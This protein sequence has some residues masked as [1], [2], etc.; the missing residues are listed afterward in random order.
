MAQR[1]THE[2]SSL[3]ELCQEAVERF[4]DDWQSIQAYMTEHLSQIAAGERKMLSKE[5]E[6]TLR[7]HAPERQKSMH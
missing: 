7:F 3:A 5:I 2:P 4:G 1:N 6:Q